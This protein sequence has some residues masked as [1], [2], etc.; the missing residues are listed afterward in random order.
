[1]GS[2]S[3]AANSGAALVA[4]AAP[5]DEHGLQFLEPLLGGV[6]ASEARGELELLD[7]R[8]QRGVEMVGRALVAEARCAARRR[9]ARA[10]P[11]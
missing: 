1:M 3:R 4:S 6:V 5:P 11:G 2:E 10:V 8:V 9:A 7:E